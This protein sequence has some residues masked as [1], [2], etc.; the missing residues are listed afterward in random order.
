MRLLVGDMNARQLNKRP[1]EQHMLGGFIYKPTI[2]RI[3]D[4][5]EEKKDN[6]RRFTETIRKASMVVMITWIE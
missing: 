4:M 1:G 3:I 6:R 5:S 2:E